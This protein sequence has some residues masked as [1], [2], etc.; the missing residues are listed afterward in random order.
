MDLLRK[1][2]A[3]TH[4]CGQLLL[5]TIDWTNNAMSL[6]LRLEL[7]S[8]LFLALNQLV[9]SL[10]LALN[11]YPIARLICGNDVFVFW[12]LGSLRDLYSW[13]VIK[14]FL[15]LGLGL[16]HSCK[17]LALGLFHSYKMLA[18]GNKCLVL[19]SRLVL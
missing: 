3:P 18:F 10:F 11:Q 6:G 15:R 8:C 12:R 1:I 13:K 14:V 17:L 4:S 7:V 2:P 5:G 16:F 9:S 19:L